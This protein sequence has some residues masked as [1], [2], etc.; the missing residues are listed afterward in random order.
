MSTVA[1]T[2]A[3]RRFGEKRRTMTAMVNALDPVRAQLAYEPILRTPG[4]WIAYRKWLADYQ[5]KLR[6][7]K[8]CCEF[9]PGPQHP[10]W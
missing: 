1:Q 3:A 8:G 7:L 4:A 9:D 5:G 2:E 6:S 10:R